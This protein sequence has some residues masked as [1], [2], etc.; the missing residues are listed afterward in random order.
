MP[1][2]WGKIC[3]YAGIAD[4]ASHFVNP[5]ST[6]GPSSAALLPD[7]TLKRFDGIRILVICD[8]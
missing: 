2:S 5:A 3:F 1:T 4:N 8:S 7:G 6:F